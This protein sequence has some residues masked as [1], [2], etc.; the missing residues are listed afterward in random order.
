MSRM[1]NRATPYLFAGLI[2]VA[3]MVVDAR[4][5]AQLDE[6]THAMRMASDTISQAFLVVAK[7]SAHSDSM[8][9]L[10]HDLVQ[11]TVLPRQRAR[12]GMLADLEAENDRQDRTIQR[13]TEALD[14]ERYMRVYGDRKKK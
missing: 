11:R 1:L 2:I 4:R 8:S 12:A 7:R 14:T 9:T 3:L 5:G 6:L 13:L 10:T